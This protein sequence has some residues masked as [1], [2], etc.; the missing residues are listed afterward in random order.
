MTARGR[1][2]LPGADDIIYFDIR[3][4][5]TYFWSLCHFAISTTPP[6]CN[7]ATTPRPHFY[8]KAS[9]PGLYIERFNTHIG[10]RRFLPPKTREHGLFSRYTHEYDCAAQ[11]RCSPR[12]AAGLL[13][14]SYRAQ[15]ATTT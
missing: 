13:D 3:C 15:R 14:E 7:N 5:N 10:S 9:G 8:H 2:L 11:L 12:A 6:F 4:Y 1:E